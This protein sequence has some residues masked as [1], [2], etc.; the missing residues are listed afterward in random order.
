M[1]EIKAIIQPFML[2]QV[3]DLAKGVNYGLQS[4]RFDDRFDFFQD[5]SP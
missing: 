2:A 3:L 4:E 1:K 5:D